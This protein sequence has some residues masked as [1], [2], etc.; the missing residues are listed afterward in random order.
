MTATPRERVQSAIRHVEPD[1]VPYHLSFTV[2]ARQRLEA[3]FGSP[4]LDEILDNHLVKPSKNAMKPAGQWN[5]VVIACDKSRIRIELNG[6]PV[7]AM[8]LDQW[9]E[10]SQRPDGTGHKFGVAW[11]DHA[12]KGYIGLQDHGKDCWF[13]NIKLKPLPD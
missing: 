3:H 6:E 1:R 9:A 12:R 5:H 7:T 13:K 2:P 8:D 4:D 11:K 10:T